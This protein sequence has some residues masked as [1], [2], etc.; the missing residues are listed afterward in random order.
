[1]KV[2]YFETGHYQPPR[3]LPARWPVA[4][5]DYDR[6]A[7]VQSYAGMVERLRL[8]ERLGF[9]WISVAEHHYSPH[10]LTPAPTV[11]AAHLAAVSQSIKIAILGP[12]VSQSNPV[13]VAE[14]LAM[15]DNLMP[16]RLIVGLLRGVTGEYLTY[17]LNPQEARERTTEAT[18]LILKAWTEPDA[19]GW[20]GRH[21]RFRTVSVWPRPA[22]QPH[23]PT[24]ALGASRESCELAARHRLGLGVAYGP[25]EVMGRAARYYREQCAQ[26]G[27]QPSS[28]Q[29]VYRANILLAKTDD[30]AE[31][32][33]A[34]RR[35]PRDSFP[36]PA[37]VRDALLQLDRRNI[38]GETRAPAI[39]GTLPINFCGSPETVVKQIE[40]CRDE[41]GAG[42]IDLMFQKPPSADLDY[43]TETLE[44]FGKKVLPCI[45]G[46]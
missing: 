44:L 14:N 31:E 34:A 28:D 10:R 32:L 35:G 18:E 30:A 7:G 41:V 19:F 20:Q 9:D 24:Y 1:V 4:P 29:I 27:W 23:P 8:V 5:D 33:L 42:V 3:Q 26:H 46:V 37:A 13:Q 43:L 11:S 21:F 40:R 17:G 38:A 12:I 2:S 25:F 45:R 39:G 6:A 22:Q 15:L 36:L 16:G